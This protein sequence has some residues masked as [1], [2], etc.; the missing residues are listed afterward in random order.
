MFKPL[1]G[2]SERAK[3][4]NQGFS[5]I[6]TKVGHVGR[7]RFGGKEKEEGKISMLEMPRVAF[8]QG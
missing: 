5:G 2:Y 3:I 8:V 7:V 1:L 4:S 6:E